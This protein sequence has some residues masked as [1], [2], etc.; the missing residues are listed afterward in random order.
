MARPTYSTDLDTIL[1]G[2]SYAKAFRVLTTALQ[3]PS[4]DPP[5]ADPADYLQVQD[6]PVP[7][8]PEPSAYDA[9]TFDADAWTDCT[10]LVSGEPTF[11]QD[12]GMPIDQLSLN[13][14]LETPT[15]TLA[16]VFQEM[17]VVLVQVRFWGSDKDTGWFNLCFCISDGYGE[18]WQPFHRYVVN[19]KCVLKLAHKDTAAGDSQVR[20]YQ[21][22]LVAVGS[23]GTHYQLTKVNED[24]DVW[25]YGITVTGPDG[26]AVQPNWADRPLPQFWCHNVTDESEPVPLAI[27]ANAVQAVFGEGI[28]RV[29]KAWAKSTP[30]TPPDY[31]QGLGFPSDESTEPDIRGIVYRYAHPA[32]TEQVAFRSPRTVP[33]DLARD[34]TVVSAAAGS[35]TVDGDITNLPEGL[36]LMAA[37]GTGRRWATTTLTLSSG[38]TVIGLQG[39]ATIDS[40]VLHYGDANLLQDVAL[41]LFIR[42]GFQR[43]DADAPFYVSVETPQLGGTDADIQLPPQ[44]V[45]DTDGSTAL[46]LLESWRSGGYAPPQWQAVSTSDGQVQIKNVVQLPDADPDILPVAHLESA[47]VDRSD[48]QVVTK[49]IA[50]GLARQVTDYSRTATISDVAEGDGGLPA[51]PESGFSDGDTVFRGEMVRSGATGYDE[52]F[53]LANLLK[54]RAVVGV[55]Y[56]SVLSKW[57]RLTNATPKTI[58]QARIRAREMRPWGW[59]YNCGA[60]ADADSIREEWRGKALCEIDL[61]SAVE[62]HGIELNVSNPWIP[63]FEQLNGLVAGEEDANGWGDNA[64]KLYDRGGGL[65]DGSRHMGVLPQWLQAQYWDETDGYWRMLASDLRSGSEFPEVIQ[66]TADAFD[67]RAEVTTSQ[68]RILCAEPTLVEAGSKDEDWYHLIV[69]VFLSRIKVFGSP[70]VRGEAEIGVTSP[71]NS[72]YWQAVRARLRR[73]TWSLPEPA[74]WV[75]TEAEANALALDWLKEYARDLAPR[76]LA[77]ARPDLRKFDTVSYTLPN[78]T[79]E[80]ALATRVTHGEGV[81]SRL[82]ATS[83]SAPYES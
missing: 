56:A 60:I 36:T 33:T 24:S 70:E 53:V 69:C 14:P 71:F 73:R 8:D 51:P 42:E 58:T 19:A 6:W 17:R 72:A 12:A 16:D 50:R 74:P 67:S 9:G 75:R 43:A 44:V 37:D 27:G 76:E 23:L 78:G 66:V 40:A 46:E 48:V 7:T 45:R 64:G 38:D 18:E 52:N 20:V 49:V 28:L 61:G 47:L 57:Q 62:V 2:K 31:S 79:A 35:V 80:Y 83:Y 25:E 4:G 1:A 30:G 54:D 82:S 32:T 3:W 22:D 63:A 59:Y 41:D 10:N 5:Y 39:N 15:A 11:T 34:L 13:V 77:V 21:P 65:G 26:A 29:G 68:L 55:S 81:M